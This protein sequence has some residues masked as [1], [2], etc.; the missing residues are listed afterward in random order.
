MGFHF[1]FTYESISL[2]WEAHWNLFIPFSLIF[3]KFQNLI[4]ME[5]KKSFCPKKANNRNFGLVRYLACAIRYSN[6][7]AIDLLCR[8]K[9]SPAARRIARRTDALT[10]RVY[11]IQTV[12][13]EASCICAFDKP[14][15]YAA[16]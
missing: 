12:L 4:M 13:Q 11:F 2:N 9:S 1:I 15:K 5:F 7:D 10:R 16:V 14:D 8:D 3:M 6:F